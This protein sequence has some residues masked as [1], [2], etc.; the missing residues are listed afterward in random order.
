MRI[1]SVASA[2]PPNIYS[3][4]SITGALHQFWD[5]A[6]K[7][8]AVLDRLQRIARSHGCRTRWLGSCSPWTSGR[9]LSGA[10]C[11]HFQPTPGSFRNS[12]RFTSARA[13]SYVSRHRA[14]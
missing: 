2:F 6:L 3:K 9:H 1:V 4:E 13:V 14:E 12:L 7:N 5:H 10:G 11:M 8:P